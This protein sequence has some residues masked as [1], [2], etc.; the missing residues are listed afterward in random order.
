M[1][2][3]LLAALLLTLSPGSNDSICPAARAIRWRVDVPA[4]AAEV[5]SAWT[6]PEGIATW[7]APAANVEPRPLGAYEILFNPEAPP[8]QRGAE[9]NLILALQEAEMLTFTWDAPP[10]LP[11]VRKQRT[12]VTVRFQ[13]LDDGSTRVWF[14]QT[15][16][17]RGGQWDEAFGYFNAAWPRVLARLHR[18]FAAEPVDWK[19]LPEHEPAESR[20]SAW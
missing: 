8:G 19:A 13:A 16:W 15:G 18:R 9:R 6:T 11:E 5:W 17:G 14:E 2:R 10:H 4:T 3:L 12:S 7:F 20:I 1:S